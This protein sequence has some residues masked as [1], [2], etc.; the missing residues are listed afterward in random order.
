MHRVVG[1]FHIDFNK[2]K[3]DSKAIPR[4]YNRALTYKEGFQEKLAGIFGLW[5]YLPQEAL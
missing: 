4:Q 1:S 3:P 2:A 5:L